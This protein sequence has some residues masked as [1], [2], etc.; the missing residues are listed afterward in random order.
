MKLH[1]ICSSIL[2]AGLFGGAAATLADDLPAGLLQPVRTETRAPM[3]V[4]YV[5]QKGGFQGNGAIYDVLLDQLLTWAE[6]AGLW[7][8][9]AKTQIVNIYPDEPSVPENEQRLWM[10]ITIPDT[11]TPPPP[12]RVLTLPAG[13]YLRGEFRV[14]ADQ[15]GAAWGYMYGAAPATLGATLADGLSC[16]IQLNDSSEDPEQKH[17]IILLVPVTTTPTVAPAPAP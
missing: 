6:P 17:H 3:R 7:D 15:F 5:E 10:G 4:A 12:I 2:L 9:P 16:E 13:T 1:S 14:T 11:A 8:F